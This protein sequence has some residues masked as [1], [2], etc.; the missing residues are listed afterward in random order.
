VKR[1]R[2]Y[3]VIVYTAEGEEQYNILATDND[4]G[5]R[6]RAILEDTNAINH[7]II[8]KAG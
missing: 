8:R 3:E 5:D 6:V 2:E 1:Y 4:I 7:K